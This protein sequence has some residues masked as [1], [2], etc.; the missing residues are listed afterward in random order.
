MSMLYKINIVD[1]LKQL[2]LLYS[3]T[4][5]RG[6]FLVFLKAQP[7]ILDCFSIGDLNSTTAS[8]SRFSVETLKMG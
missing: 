7:R 5:H 3:A 1:F 6:I 8:V 2:C 4:S